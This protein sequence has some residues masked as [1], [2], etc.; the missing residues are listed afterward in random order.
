MGFGSSKKIKLNDIQNH[1]LKKQRE[2]NICKILI[3]D[4]DKGFGFL[5]LLSRSKTRILITDTRTLSEKDI[6][7]KKDLKIMIQNKIISIDT[8][9]PRAFYMAEK[10]E[11]MIFEINE[12]DDL[13]E[14]N[15][16]EF[17][18]KMNTDNPNKEYKKVNIYLLPYELKE[19]N[20]PV[21]EIKSIDNKDYTIEHNCSNIDRD[22]FLAPILKLDNNKVLGFNKFKNNGIFL[23]VF[24]DEFEKNEKKL[25]EQKKIQE[26][27]KKIKIFKTPDIISKPSYIIILLEVKEKDINKEIYFFDAINNNRENGFMKE[28][29]KSKKEIKIDITFPNQE[30]PKNIIFDN[31]FKPNIKGNYQLEIKLQK[32]IKDCGYMFCGCTNIYDI[33]LSNFDHSEITN[34]NDMFNNCI[35]LKKIK[36]SNFEIKNVTDMSYMFNYCKNLKEIKFPKI[37]TSKVISMEGMFQSCENLEEIN[38]EEFDAHHVTKLSSMFNDCYNLKQI[39]FSPK[40]ITSKAKYMLWMFYGCENLEEIDLSS[41]S[42]SHKNL[43]DMTN[44]FEGCEKLKKIFVREEDITKFRY[45]HRKIHELFKTRDE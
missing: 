39:K 30:Q 42:I 43:K 29:E 41:F 2:R 12:K 40:F 19:Q 32:R 9:I 27:P 16:L 18:N 17:D 7:N 13:N 45:N 8:N 26:E 10:R 37:D 14:D 24:L 1:Q 5:C 34:M 38:L 35:N 4:E 23:K 28:I 15:F 22:N 20:Y 33:D 25:R 31:K 3:N 21:G 6:K 36:F 44:M 11:I